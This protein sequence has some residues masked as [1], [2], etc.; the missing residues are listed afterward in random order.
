[1][2]AAYCILNVLGG[3]DNA[4]KSVPSSGGHHFVVLCCY[5]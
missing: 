3:F 2:Y 1:V 4:S 5:P